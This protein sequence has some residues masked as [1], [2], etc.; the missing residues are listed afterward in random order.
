MPPSDADHHPV[1]RRTFVAVLIV[2][3]LVRVGL[4]AL[5]PDEDIGAYQNWAYRAAISGI[6]ASYEGSTVDYPPV[7][8]YVLY[9]IGKVYEKYQHFFV[10]NKVQHFVP[11]IILVKLPPLLFDLVIAALL[12]ALVA[13]AGLWRAARAT[14]AWGRV[15]ALL[16]L[17]N[18]AVLWTSGFYGQF[19]SIHTALA[20]AALAALGLR[21]FAASGALLAASGLMKPLAAPLVPILVA[22]AA[23]ARGLPGV[24]AGC[25]AGVV[26]GV[27]IFLPFISTGRFIATVERILRD[28]N[29]MPFTSLNSHN[30]WMAVGAWRPSN[31]A[32]LGPITPRHIGLFLFCATSLLLIARSWKWLSGE[33]IE[34]SDYLARLFLLAAAVHC[35]FFFFSVN[36]HENHLFECIP[37]LL[38]VAGRSRAMAIMAG[39]CSS[40]VVVNFVVHNLDFPYT[41]RFSLSARSPFVDPYLVYDSRLSSIIHAYGTDLHYTW[42]QIVAIAAN[43]VAVCGLTCA[44]IWFTWKGHIGDRHDNELEA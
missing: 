20:V 40:V 35:S 22:T 5:S 14:P 44:T 27:M 15:A 29:S 30:L 43:T 24:A 18:P 13:R 26:T 4:S 42:L 11:F 36:M 8:L 10:P 16:Y 3:L 2:Y 32:V 23:A 38:L 12:Y 37:L 41:L 34:R 19:D 1:S 6:A 28:L 33:G 31:L 17:W 7:I 25:A 39:I 9:P 21:Q